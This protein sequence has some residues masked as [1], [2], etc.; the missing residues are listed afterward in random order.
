MSKISTPFLGIELAA[1]GS[2]EPFR[3]ADVNAAFTV[4]DTWA[5][6]VDSQL[7]AT[8]AVLAGLAAGTTPVAAAGLTGS[9]TVAHGGTG[10][11]TVTT[12]REGLRVFVQETQPS[13]PQA[14]DLWFW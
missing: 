7:T 5:D 2:Q 8:A 4:V 9:V 10:G 1:P 11:T 13:A 12:A 3:T 6:T 14:G